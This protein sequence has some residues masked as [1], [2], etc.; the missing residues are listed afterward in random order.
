MTSGVC[1]NI[2]LARLHIRLYIYQKDFT[3]FVNQQVNDCLFE[4]FGSWNRT[5]AA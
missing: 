3:S 1:C 2:N 5:F 4:W